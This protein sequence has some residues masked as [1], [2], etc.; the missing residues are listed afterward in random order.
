MTPQLSHCL[1]QPAENNASPSLTQMRA[2]QGA[3]H[4]QQQDW[5][6][7]PGSGGTGGSEAVLVVESV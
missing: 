7:E 1:L 3:P 2:G 5:P 4:L 6:L